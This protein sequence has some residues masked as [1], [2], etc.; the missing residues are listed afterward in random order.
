MNA[1]LIKYEKGPHRTVNTNKIR[2]VIIRILT[3]SDG[4]IF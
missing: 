4:N 1:T 2:Q 3:L